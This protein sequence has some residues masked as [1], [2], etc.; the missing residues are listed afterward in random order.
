M[1][2]I[3]PH[4]DK[5]H[6]ICWIALGVAD[7]LECGAE[8]FAL[9]RKVIDSTNSLPSQTAPTVFHL[10]PLI[11][12]TLLCLYVALLVPLPFLS[13]VTAAPI[14]PGLLVVGICIGAVALYAALSERV[15]L[16]DQGIQVTYPRWVPRFFR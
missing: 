6:P 7:G 14:P 4:W 12:I 15:I 3:A 16:D 9:T 2:A 13:Q 5:Y 10:S 8:I 1:G 11:R